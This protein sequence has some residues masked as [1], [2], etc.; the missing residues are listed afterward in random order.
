MFT[1]KQNPVPKSKNNHVYQ[2]R[3]TNI[4]QC[5]IDLILYFTEKP[6]NQVHKKS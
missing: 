5:L 3:G 4:V 2:A 6:L 1:Y